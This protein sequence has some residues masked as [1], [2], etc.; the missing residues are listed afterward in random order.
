MVKKKKLSEEGG[1]G[2]KKRT[3]KSVLCIMM[4]SHRSFKIKKYYFYCDLVSEFLKSVS[5]QEPLKA[6]I[7]F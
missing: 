4:T 2:V 6:E 5:S 1:G 7:F 3:N